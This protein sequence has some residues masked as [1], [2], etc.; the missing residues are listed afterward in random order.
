M[1]GTISKAIFGEEEEELLEEL[2]E[3]D[4][5]V[6]TNEVYP[7]DDLDFRRSYA[8]FRGDGSIHLGCYISGSPCIFLG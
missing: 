5:A 7:L 6:I 3:G 2:L 8:S 1:F 4:A